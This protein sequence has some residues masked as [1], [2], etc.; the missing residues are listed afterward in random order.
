L[1]KGKLNG[2]VDYFIKNSNNILLEVIPADPIQPAGT[3][4]TNVEDMTITNSGIEFE[5][6]YRGNIN[7]DM[8]FS[9]SANAAFLKNI[10]ENSPYSV[11]QSGSASGAG[12]TSATINGYINGQPIGTFFLREWTGFDAQGLS[13]YKDIDGDGISGDKDRQA[14]GTALPKVI[15]AF[16]GNLSYKSFDLVANFNGVSGNKIYD[17]T[18]NASF[19]KNRLSKSVNTTAEAIRDAKE[20]ISNSAPVSSRYL[21]DGA[22]L[23][24]NNLALGYS[25]DTRNSALGKAVSSLRLSVTGQNLFVITK[26][27][28][29]DP[30][31][32]A[33]R[34]INGISSYGIDLLS[35]PK[36]RS[37]VFGLNV[38][39]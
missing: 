5:L 6:E 33:D 19:Y 12:L 22:Y 39:F 23:R 24:L 9:V 26:Y 32:N 35:Y 15:Y 16:S 10:V 20:S 7:K 11:I 30:E 3:F 37:I 36:A 38:T 4:W 1:L 2:S 27:D 17:N 8:K 31:V 21:K 13:T 18:A 34:T 29:Y 25:F 28:G 14:M